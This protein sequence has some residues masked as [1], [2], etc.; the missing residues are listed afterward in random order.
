M[1]EILEGL[2]VG[3]VQELNEVIKQLQEKGFEIS[4]DDFGAGY[5]SLNVLGSLE[6]NELKLDRQ[7][8][9]PS[10]ADNEKKQRTIMKNIVRLAKDLSIRIVV[11]GVETKENE[12][13]IKSIGCDTGQGYYYSRPIPT[14]EFEDKFMKK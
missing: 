1:L 7:F 2:A 8:L 11:E 13:F 10:T 9:M 6:I 5:S 12:E 3:N 14:N 4:M